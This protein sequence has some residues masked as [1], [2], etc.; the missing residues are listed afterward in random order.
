M[1]AL[2]EA[3]RL[4]HERAKLAIEIF[5]YRL[6]KSLLGLVASLDTIDALVFTG[7]IGENSAE[8]RA[9]TVAYLK[10]LGVALDDDKNTVNGRLDGGRISTADSHIPCLVIPTN[11]E[12]MIARETLQLI[13]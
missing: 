7:G 2:S 1:R 11:E 10:I 6:A 3:A 4:G 8:V 5:C 12:L 13:P 9:L